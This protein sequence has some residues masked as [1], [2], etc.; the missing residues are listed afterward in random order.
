MRILREL[1]AARR[2]R[3]SPGIRRQGTGTEQAERD[4]DAV[5][6][7]VFF[8]VLIPNEIKLNKIVSADF[9][10]FAREVF[11]TVD[12][13]SV[14]SMWLVVGIR[15]PEIVSPLSGAFSIGGRFPSVSTLGYGVSSLRDSAW[16]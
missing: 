5:A 7:F 13:A 3:S 1:R 9:A 10:G 16:A 12:S 8:Q 14:T 2:R 6:L 11:V 15:T 4:A